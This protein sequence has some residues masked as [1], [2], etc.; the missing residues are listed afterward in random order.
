MSKFEEYLEATKTVGSMSEKDY[1]KAFEDFNRL[2]LKLNLDE[3]F[4][5]RKD[6]RKKL[7]NLMGALVDV[8]AELPSKRENK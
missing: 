8:K 3:N 4:M 6:F 7:N 1:I 2:L 5:Y